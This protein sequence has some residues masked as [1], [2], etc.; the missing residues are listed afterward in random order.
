MKVKNLLYWCGLCWRSYYAVIAQKNPNIFVTVVDAIKERIAAW[1]SENLNELPIYE[2]GL[3]E[4]IVKLEEEIYFSNEIDN[5]IK[6]L[7]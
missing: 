1:N 6:T 2:P 3:A 5:A 7:K 4:V